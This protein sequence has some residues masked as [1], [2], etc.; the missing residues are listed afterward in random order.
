MALRTETPTLAKTAIH[1][2]A[3]SGGFAISLKEI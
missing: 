3:P 2:M 1:I